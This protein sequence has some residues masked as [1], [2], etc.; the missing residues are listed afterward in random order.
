MKK[1]NEKGFTLAELLIV[2]AIIAV[3]VAV[4]IPTFTDQL[5][6]AR[7]A[8]DIS[9]LRSAYAQIVTAA[10]ESPQTS[11]TIPVDI[12]QSRKG[13]QTETVEI[14]GAD[15]INGENAMEP[16]ANSTL[17]VAYNKATDDTDAYITIAG[18]M[19]TGTFETT[20]AKGYI[21]I[22]TDS[23]DGKFTDATAF[24]TNTQ[25]K[26][27]YDTKTQKFTKSTTFKAGTAYY[28]TATFTKITTETFNS[29]TDYYTGTPGGMF[30]KQT[31]ST[32]FAANTIYYTLNS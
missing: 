4:A 13:W 11:T 22:K 3:L 30:N 10:L 2:V 9:N 29:E 1:V 6:K 31:L 18:V 8:T 26:Y 23:D 28:T 5:E 20:T 19:V 32:G 24:S 15:L 14:A 25:D 16:Q 7:E 21:L 17:N 12:R 27:T